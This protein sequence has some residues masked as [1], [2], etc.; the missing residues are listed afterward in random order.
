MTGPQGG[1]G[2][3]ANPVGRG[4]GCDIASLGAEIRGTEL[5]ARK[6]HQRL[7]GVVDAAAGRRCRDVAGEHAV[8][9]LLLVHPAGAAWQRRGCRQRQPE[10]SEKSAE[11]SRAVPRPHHL[12]MLS[13][14][15]TSGAVGASSR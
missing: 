5:L 12:T 3:Q 6:A 14:N 4:D 8:V 2:D 1:S 13:M 7:A 11:K 9:E 15:I 10:P